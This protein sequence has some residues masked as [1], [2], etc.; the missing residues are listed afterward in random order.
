[1]NS[2]HQPAQKLSQMLTD[3]VEQGSGDYISIA[4]LVAGIKTQALALL[5][6]LFA[7]PN[8]LPSLPGTSAITGLPLVLLTLQMTFGQGVWLPKVIGNRAVPRAGLLLVLQR[9]LPYFMRIER[10]LYPRLFWVTTYIGLRILGALMVVLSLIIMLPIP[11]ANSMPAL[12]IAVIAIGLTERDGLFIIAGI[13]VAAGA[14]AV[15]IVL[16]WTLIA[17]ALSQAAAWF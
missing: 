13:V 6:I 8:V 15:M 10:L 4:D 17:L 7:L 12:A 2:P 9:S 1:M 3:A 11:L 5:L 14:V 16:Y